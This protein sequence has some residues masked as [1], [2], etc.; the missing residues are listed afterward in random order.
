MTDARAE[1]PDLAGW[2]FIDENGVD[3]RKPVKLSVRPI[4]R[5]RAPKSK[6]NRFK[7]TVNKCADTSGWGTPV[8]SEP[9]QADLVAAWNN[10]SPSTKDKSDPS[11]LNVELPIHSPVEESS[12]RFRALMNRSS[13]SQVAEQP[14][15]LPLMTGSSIPDVKVASISQSVSCQTPKTPL[16]SQVEASKCSS[17]KPSPAEDQ[18][19]SPQIVCEPSRRRVVSSCSFDCS[20]SDET[21]QLYDNY[22]T[23]Q[24][25]DDFSDYIFYGKVEII[26]KKKCL[27]VHGDRCFEV[28]GEIARNRALHGD[29]VALFI[30]ATENESECSIVRV[31]QR[32]TTNDRIM[33]AGRFNYE[34]GVEYQQ[35]IPSDEKQPQCLV[36]HSE[37]MKSLKLIRQ[38]L[39]DPTINLEDINFVVNFYSWDTN[40]EFP[41][42]K[43]DTDAVDYTIERRLS[44]IEQRRASQS[45][46]TPEVVEKPD[47]KP[48]AAPAKKPPLRRVSSGKVN[49]KSRAYTEYLSLDEVQTGYESGELEVGFLSVTSFGSNAFVS[50]PALDYDICIEGTI[51][52]NRAYSGDRVAI[53]LV[54]SETPSS[55]KPCGEVVS[56]V[57]SSFNSETPVPG[58]VEAWGTIPISESTREC[59]FV[60]IDS[61]IPAASLSMTQIPGD[62]SGDIDL[63]L[64]SLLCVNYLPWNVSSRRPTARYCDH[65]GYKGDMH[66]E[67]NGLLLK[68][69]IRHSETFSSQVMQEAEAYKGWIVSDSDR[70]SREDFTERRVFSITQSSTKGIDSALSVRETAA[71]GLEVCVHVSDVVHFANPGSHLDREAR[72]RS[73]T[74]T[75]GNSCFPILPPVLS[76]NICS[77]IPGKE[78]LSYSVVFK[79]DSNGQVDTKSFDFIRSIVRSQAKLDYTTAQAC[80]DMDPHCTVDAS[81]A[82]DIRLLNNVASTRRLKRKQNGALDLSVNELSFYVDNATDLPIYFE[83]KIPNQ[84]QLMV[85]E[86]LLIA[87]EFCARRQLMLD[88]NAA[89]LRVHS[90]SKFNS[91]LKQLCRHFKI[92]PTL[93]TPL[94]YQNTMSA[95]ASIPV[96]SSFTAADI[97]TSHVN[98]TFSTLS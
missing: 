55:K 8:P 70:Q 57:N 69:G 88:A 56:I 79:I 72:K 78:R 83:K 26:S 19:K 62:L 61:R 64:D 44:D 31:I 51:S 82:N 38:K 4:D 93:E 49:A 2:G 20:D 13:Q 97:L 6:K 67:I 10:S 54:S 46:P 5:T 16:D 35:F 91:E 48:S 80:I 66:T 92:D 52:R 23:L 18:F 77:L 3:T 17:V 36:L 71:G 40:S 29:F 89:I 39:G 27:V 75:I 73:S 15:S 81:I 1:Y 74:I 41:Y 85:E 7:L 98:V 9:A 33:Y 42:A 58:Y 45:T 25:L 30:P 28:I 63:L 50:I 84:A 14:L 22:Y 43:I 59:K 96:G 95:L 12:S 53:R 65:L 11:P 87:N 37:C 68:Y 86:L 76:H 24:E 21:D 90:S 34:S 60:P 94:D 32:Q 47:P